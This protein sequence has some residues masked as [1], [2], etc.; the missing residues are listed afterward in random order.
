MDQVEQQAEGEVANK[1]KTV[2]QAKS[3]KFPQG[4]EQRKYMERG[5]AVD[6]SEFPVCCNPECGH[7]FLDHPISNLDAQENNKQAMIDYLAQMEKL[8]LSPRQGSF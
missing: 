2:G 3:A 6:R 7:T 8:R 5:I 4:E 1:K